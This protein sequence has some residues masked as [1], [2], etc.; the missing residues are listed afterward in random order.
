[1]Y[2]SNRG[3]YHCLFKQG[4]GPLRKVMEYEDQRC[5]GFFLLELKRHR[6]KLLKNTATQAHPQR[7]ITAFFSPITPTNATSQS[8]HTHMGS[9]PE[10]NKGVT[11]DRAIAYTY[12]PVPW[13]TISTPL[14]ST[15]KSHY[16]PPSQVLPSLQRP[17]H[18]GWTY[19]GD[20]SKTKVTIHQT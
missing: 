13:T 11:I 15:D 4:F 7:T 16:L 17:F 5:L 8:T 19:A 12:A 10:H 1:M 20:L 14:S 18:S 3:R 2:L 6:E 9:R